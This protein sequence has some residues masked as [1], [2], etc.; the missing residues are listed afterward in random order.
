ME[1]GHVLRFA[2]QEHPFLVEATPCLDPD[3]FCSLVTLKLLQVVPPGS[4][5]P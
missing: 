5:P 3:C 2:S 1:T 4:A